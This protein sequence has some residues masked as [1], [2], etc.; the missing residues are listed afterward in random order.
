[1]KNAETTTVNKLIHTIRKTVGKKDITIKISLDDDCR[2]GHNDFS[3]TADIY[4]A[5]KPHTDRYFISGGCCHEEILK[6]MPEL[7]IFVD[8]HLA[9]VTGARMYAID[10]G[11][12]HLQGVIG[13]AEHNHTLTLSKFAEYM[14][15]TEQ[16]AQYLCE[17]A[18]DQ[19]IFAYHL[20][21][22]GIVEQWK[23]EANKAIQIL[24]EWTG[25]KFE[26][27]SERLPKILL[28]PEE[29]QEVEIKIASGYYTPASIKQR[30]NS[31][32]EAKKQAALS[33]IKESRDKAIKNENDEYN[34]KL[35]VLKLGYSL[36]N[37]IYYNHTNTGSFNWHTSSYN[38]A[39]TQEEFNHFLKLL[40]VYDGELP[41][42]IKF[43]LSKNK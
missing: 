29:K 12:Y 28:T 18:P 20:E 8:L 41:E 3:I 9:D 11:F 24:E 19:Q 39:I 23:Q 16:Q 17:N 30:Q 6:V 14:R 37:F 38:K 7:K 27:D 13:T 2:N 4:T 34:V 33:V 1:M 35:A 22:M 5:G 25:N 36:D 31:S 32:A 15:I 21:K 43:E 26:D 42:G 40:E 10:N